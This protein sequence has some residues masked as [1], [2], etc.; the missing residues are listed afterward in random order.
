VV[1]DVCGVDANVETTP[2]VAVAVEVGATLVAGQSV[3]AVD[4][5]LVEDA[6]E[7]ELRVGATLVAVMESRV[8][9]TL[10]VVMA[11]KVGAA[12]VPSPVETEDFVTVMWVVWKKLSVR[13]L[14]ETY[15]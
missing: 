15:V 6:A 11:L 5:T 2:V 13:D 7:V 14:L 10:V 9:P 12:P 8:K 4:S 3:S 1:E